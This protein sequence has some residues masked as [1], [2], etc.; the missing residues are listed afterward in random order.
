[1]KATGAELTATSGTVPGFVEVATP[2]SGATTVEIQ[3]EYV[4]ER[5]ADYR[6]IQT[7]KGKPVAFGYK[8]FVLPIAWNVSFY[9]WRLSENPIEPHAAPD[10]KH[11]RDVIAAQPVKTLKLAA[12]DFAGASFDP[13]VGNDHYLTIATGEFDAPAG[14]YELEMTTDDGA[15]LWLDGKLLI[16]DAWHYQ[17]PTA[18]SRAVTLGGRHTIR[19]EHFQIDGYAALK[20]KLKPKGK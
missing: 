20:V 3:L 12:L 10:S 11:F 4:G 2:E 9:K 16:D 15:R 19:V 1:M 14:E 8:K 7:A 5:T 13:V 17:A 18:Y 6:G